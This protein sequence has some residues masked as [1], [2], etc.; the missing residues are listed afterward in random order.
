[1]SDFIRVNLHRSAQPG[2]L[3]M[4]LWRCFEQRSIDPK[5]HYLNP[6]QSQ[7]WLALHKKYAPF[8]ACATGADVYDSAF[9]WVAQNLPAGAVELVSLACGG[10]GKELRLVKR[11]RSA[12]RN[13]FATVSDISVPLVVEGQ[14]TL[15]AGAWLAEIETVVLDLLEAGDLNRILP[16][17][18]TRAAS[19][20]VTC[21]GLMPNVDPLVIA[22]RLQS[23][24]AKN[25]VL[26]VGANLVP[27]ADYAENTRQI[28]GGYDNAETRGWLSLLLLD[29]GFDPADGEIVFTVEPCASL[30]EL[31]Q[32]VARFHLRRERTIQLAG[33]PLKFSAGENLRLFF[34]NRFTPALLRRVLAMQKLKILGAWVSAEETEGVIACGSHAHD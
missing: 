18:R 23:L 32:I 3:A 31:L 1:M 25:D 4:A 19:R 2:Q 26:L 15:S 21:F 7:A 8:A 11:L 17:D 13:I 14:Q 24:P 20:I 28:L 29:A 10:A 12:G 33:E 9:N 30:P 34:S 6:R 22:A 27:E 16:A 5:F